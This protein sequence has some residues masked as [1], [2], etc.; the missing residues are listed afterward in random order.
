[1]SAVP[2]PTGLRT[3]LEISREKLIRNYQSIRQ[4]VGE[5]IEVAAVVKADAYGHGAVEVART[6]ESA[7]AGWFAVTSV[8]EAIELRRAA[9]TGRILV[10]AESGQLDALAEF[11]LTPVLHSVEQVE[12]L[13]SWARRREI[14]PRFHLKLDTGMG[15][16]GLH[17]APAA[18]MAGR[19]SRCPHL[20]LEGLA[21]HLASAEDF[22]SGQTEEQVERFHRAVELF[23]AQGLRPRYLHLANSAALA[24]RPPTWGSMVRPGLALY[25]CLMP[26]RGR[27]AAA[28]ALALH[29]ILNWRARILAVKDYA[30]GLPLGYDAAYRTTRPMRIGVIAA[31]YADGLDRR[32]SNGGPVLAGGRR[33][34]IVGLV[35][36]DVS[37]VDLTACPELR[38]GGSV[39]LLGQDGGARL[40]AL[41]LAGHCQTIPYEILC[42]IGKRVARQPSD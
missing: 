40:D 18:E 16:L 42:R 11:R 33:T 4:T 34:S 9:V 37:L 20:L 26:P 22:H 19:L 29:P 10:L 15:R 38:P 23:A 2:A 3:W 41:E 39:T 13:E 14:R 28:S 5:A 7:G 6:L 35:S 12:E 32:L 1:L 24:Y 36:M 8:A 30:A 21:T 25:G 17:E 31:G 27:P